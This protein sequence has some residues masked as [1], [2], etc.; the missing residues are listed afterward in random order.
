MGR[1]FRKKRDNEITDE[2]IGDF[3]TFDRYEKMLASKEKVVVAKAAFQME[4]RG[5]AII[6][7]DYD[8]KLKMQTKMIKIQT[9]KIK[10]LGQ[11][12]SVT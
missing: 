9:G 12:E 4:A 11:R 7:F 5:K 1:S 6:A 8:K 10:R 3:I 2:N